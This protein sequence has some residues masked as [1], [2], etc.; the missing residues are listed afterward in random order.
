MSTAAVR[1]RNQRTVQEK[2]KNFQ[3]YE[4]QKTEVEIKST[5]V[6]EFD[7]PSISSL[8]SILAKKN[9]ILHNFTSN[10]TMQSKRFK[11]STFVET[12]Q[13][14]YQWFLR[15]RA[16]KVE[17]SSEFMIHQAK[18]IAASENVDNFKTSKGY[19]E[20]FKSRYNIALKKTSRR[21]YCCEH[22]LSTTGLLRSHIL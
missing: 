18:L 19:V 7:L 16:K 2:Y 5:L 1:K 8:K 3:A 21:G 11:P 22:K 13:E 4:Q 9:E 20:G 14:L 10:F 6:P 15:M 12:D 17:L